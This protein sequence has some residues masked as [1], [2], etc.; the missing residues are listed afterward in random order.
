MSTIDS[1]ESTANA[2]PPAGTEIDPAR[3]RVAKEYAGIQRR[4]FFIE[5]GV[6]ALVLAALLFTGWSTALR[7]WIEGL[8]TDSWLV[9]GLYGVALGAIFVVLTLP[10]DFYSGYILPRRYGL[11]TQSAAGWVVDTVKN[12]ALGAAFGLVGIEVLYWVLRSFPDYW[13]AIISLLLWLFTVVMAQLAP[14]LIMPIFYKFRPLDDPELVSRLTALADRAGAKVRGVYVMDMSSRTTT[15]NAM[16]AGLGS[17]RR[18]ILGDTL[19]RDYSHDEIETILAHELAHHVHNDLLKGL[20]AQAVIIPVS[21]WVASVLLSWGVDQFGF[22]GIDDVA[23]LPLLIAALS[24][25]GLL[26]MPAANLLSRS[27]ERAAD[28]YALETTHNRAAFRSVMLKLANQNLSDMDP[29]AWVR[30]L[31]YSHPPISERV[32][33]AE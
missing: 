29:P 16:L 10:L 3:Q 25:F 14:V 21:M 2:T 23:A 1:A 33:M 26:T 20:A 22:R 27:M 11:L 31:F 28:R 4:F 24:I 5:M 15:A 7:G 8:S 30:F 32:R 12:L 18:I 9:V 19:L 17:T 6:M 13:W